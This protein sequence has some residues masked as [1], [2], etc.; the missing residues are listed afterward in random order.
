MKKRLLKVII[1]NFLGIM[2]LKNA[3]AASQFPHGAKDP[4]IITLE[5]KI[6]HLEEVV[7]N[8]E[9]EERHWHKQMTEAQQR[10]QELHSEITQIEKEKD[11]YLDHATHEENYQRRLDFDGMKRDLERLQKENE[12]LR[13]EVGRFELQ[14]DNLKKSV[15]REKTEAAER[16]LQIEAAHKSQL[17]KSSEL[18]KEQKELLGKQALTIK[19]LKNEIEDLKTDEI[20]YRRMGEELLVAK[21]EITRLQDLLHG[22]S[23]SPDSKRRDWHL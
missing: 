13:A 15:S 16:V 12:V 10:E 4:Y 5:K 23:S 20:E 3:A 17:E 6:K 1:L 19:D 8:Y 11:R 2:I 14:L 9:E 18:L 21:K 22:R 7:A